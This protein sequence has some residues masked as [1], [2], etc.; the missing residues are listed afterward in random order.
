MKTTGFTRLFWISIL[1]ISVAE[2]LCI[3]TCY[4]DVFH[5][6][7]GMI[8]WVLDLILEK[9]MAT[10][11]SVLAWRIPGTGEP[12]GLLSMV[13]HRVGHDWSDLASVLIYCQ[14][15]LFWWS[16]IT[17]LYACTHTHTHAHTLSLSLSLTHTHIFPGGSAITESPAMQETSLPCG[18]SE[19]DSWVRKIPYRRKWQTTP[20]FLPG[21]SHGQRSLAGYSP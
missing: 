1:G 2:G 18:K 19:F 13:S 16:I 21:K 11:S 6:N 20:V 12:V 10:H 4:K 17:K 5:T 3:W 14:A 7:R 9:E 15:K 8:W